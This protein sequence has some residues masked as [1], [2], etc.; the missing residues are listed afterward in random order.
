MVIIIAH[1]TYLY[2]TIRF[3]RYKR[4]VDGEEV[5]GVSGYA[6]L[7][8]ARLVGGVYHRQCPLEYVLTRVVVILSVAIVDKRGPRTGPEDRRGDSVACLDI[9]QMQSKSS[10]FGGHNNTFSSTKQTLSH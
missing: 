4:D 1:S 9:V 3:F 8:R 5:I 7:H 10:S 2:I 6:E